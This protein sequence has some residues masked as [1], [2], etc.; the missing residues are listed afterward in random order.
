MK[1]RSRSIFFD[2]SGRARSVSE[3]YSVLS[4][5]YAGAASSQAT[6][7]AMAAVGDTPTR[8]TFA[9]AAVSTSM[10]A[11]GGLSWALDGAAAPAGAVLRLRESMDPAGA[12]SPGTRPATGRSAR[13]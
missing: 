5:R 13:R 12:L 7:T 6:R 10:I 11:F 2:R 4:S 3:V 9:S 8:V 1:P